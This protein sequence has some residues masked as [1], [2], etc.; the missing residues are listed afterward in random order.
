M[1]M[2]TSKAESSNLVIIANWRIEEGDLFGGKYTQTREYYRKGGE[3]LQKI[4]RLGGNSS[5]LV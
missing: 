2:E 4:D 1:T 5:I 3:S